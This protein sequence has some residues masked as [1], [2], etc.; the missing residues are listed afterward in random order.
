MNEP[1]TVL[2]DNATLITLVTITT[3]T[4]ITVITSLYSLHIRK[5]ELKVQTQQKQFD[6]YY[7][8]KSNA[9][10]EFVAISSSLVININDGNIFDKVLSAT[11]KAMLLCNEEN[12][13]LLKDFAEFVDNRLFTSEKP[14]SE[15]RSSYWDKLSTVTLSL[16]K[17]L[18]STSNLISSKRKKCTKS[19]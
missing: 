1:V 19:Q 6:L 14:T 11:H 12:K 7:T 9:F 17:E 13:P 3:S 15:W 8:E 2:I 16:N 18:R 4:L 10:R 5:V